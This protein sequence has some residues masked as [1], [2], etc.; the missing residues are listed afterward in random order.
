[1]VARVKNRENFSA[2]RSFT[3]NASMAELQELTLPLG[4]KTFAIRT[5]PIGDAVLSLQGGGV[6][7]GPSV[8]LS[9]SR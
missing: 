1:M 9:P 8:R 3:T 4:E 2:S 7:F 6:A 5:P